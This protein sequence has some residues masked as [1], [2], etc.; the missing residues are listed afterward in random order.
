MVERNM[1]SANLGSGSKKRR[2]YKGLAGALRR[3]KI[4]IASAASAAMLLGQ[5]AK[6]TTDIWSNGA[7]DGLWDTGANWGNGASPITTDDVTF[8]VG[9]YNNILL[10]SGEVANSLTFNDSSYYLTGG[11]LTLGTGNITVNTPFIDTIS[12]TLNGSS[13]LSLAGGGTLNL[14]NTSNGFTGTVTITGSTLNIAG[15][16]SLGTSSNGITFSGTSN[17]NLVNGGT[18]LGA[19]RTITL[20]AAATTDTITSSTN[21]IQTLAGQITGAANLTVTNTGPTLLANSTNNFTGALW[22]QNGTAVVNSLADAPGNGNIRLGNGGSTGVFQWGT[23][24]TGPLTLNNRQIELVGTTGG[25]TIDSSAAVQANTVTINSNLLISTNGAKTLTLQGNNGGTLSS[26]AGTLTGSANTFAGTITDSASGA[27]ALTK[28]GMGLWALTGTGNTY[29]GLTTISTGTLRIGASVASSLTPGNLSLGAA[30]SGATLELR[31][32]VG[33]TDFQNI[34][35]SGSN[36]INSAI[37]YADRAIGNTTA[38]NQTMT[39]GSFYTPF[40]N[41]EQTSL[42][43]DHGYSISIG[44]VKVTPGAATTW[45]FNNF[46]GSPAYVNGAY[47]NG[48]LTL[49][50]LTTDATAGTATQTLAGW[51]DYNLGSVSAAAAN[52]T[53]NLTYSSTGVL[54]FT[55]NNSGWVSTTPGVLSLNNGITRLTGAAPIGTATITFNG[56]TVEFRNDTATNASGINISGLTGNGTI[57][58][59]HTLAGSGSS[60]LLT[61]GTFAATVSKILYVFGD[62]GN[63]LTFSGA[64]T[65][66]GGQ[67][68]VIQNYLNA[69]GFVTAG[70]TPGVLTFGALKA[71]NTAGTATINLAGVGDYVI[72]G[73]ISDPA[74]AI[75]AI[76]KSGTGV[77][78]ITSANN[79]GWAAKAAAVLSLTGGTTRFTT[80]S[81]IGSAGISFGGGMLELR[82]DSPTN[83][84]TNISALTATST[85]EVANSLTGSGN[86]NVMSLGNFAANGTATLNVVGD[87]GN[88][89]TFTGTT[90]VTG[91]KTATIANFLN[92]P[93][94]VTSG[95]APGVITLGAITNDATAGTANLTL[96]GFGDYALTGNITNA[97][98]ATVAL[99]ITK[100]GQGVLTFGGSNTG[101]TGNVGDV[102]TLTSGTTRLTGASP[103]GGAAITL[104]GGLL[105]L[106]NDANTNVATNIAGVTATSTLLLDHSIGNTTDA[107]FV[108]TIGTLNS[109][110]GGTLY[111][112]GDRGYGLTVSGATT[113]VG[114]RTL[115][116]ANFLSAPGYSG[117]SYTPG[118]ITLTNVNGDGTAGVST[119][120][121]SGFGDFNAFDGTTNII[122]AGVGNTAGTTDSLNITKSNLGVATFSGN[123]VNWTSTAQGILSTTLGT[124]RIDVANTN[125][126]GGA[127]LSLGGGMTEIR[128]NASTSWSSH[129]LT[130]NNAAST[131]VVAP[132]IGSSNT[133]N[134]VAL[135]TFTGAGSTVSVDTNHNYG[136]TF[137]AG[138]ASASSVIAN[139]GNGLISLASLTN[140]ATSTYT[141]SGNGDFAVTGNILAGTGTTALTK[142]GY[143]TLALS[144][145]GDTYTG[146]ITLTAGILKITNPLGAAIG[147]LTFN[148]TGSTIPNNNVIAVDLRNN[149]NGANNAGASVLDISTHPFSRAINIVFNVDNNGAGTNGTVVVGGGLSMQDSGWNILVTGGNGYS[150]KF[151]GSAVTNS[152]GTNT[153]GSSYTVFNYIPSIAGSGDLEFAGGLTYINPVTQTAILTL[154]GT[155]D[156]VVSGAITSSATT[157]AGATTLTKSGLGTLTLSGNNSTSY[158]DPNRILTMTN[159]ITR[160]ST[161]ANLGGANLAGANTTLNLNGATLD[162]RNDLG[163]TFTE[164]VTVGAS[165]S[166]INVDQSIGGSGTGQ[167]M[168]LG[169]LK[170]GAFTAFFTNGNNYSLN[171][172][173]LTQTGTN[174]IVN[175]ISGT[176]NLIIPSIAGAQATTFTGSGFTIVSGPAASSL[177]AVTK[178]GTGTVT[179]QEPTA[180]SNTTGNLV[181]NAGSLVADYSNGITNGILTA[182]DTLTLAGGTF[183]L[184]SSNTAS[185]S[186]SQ[187]LGNVAVNAGG[188][189][190]TITPQNG[191]TTILNA[192][193]LATTALGSTLLVNS[194]SVTGVV[195]FNSNLSTIGGRVVL[196]DGANYNWATNSGVNS[197]TTAFTGY[198]S[199]PSSGTFSTTNYLQTDSINVTSGGTLNTLKIT[200]TQAGQ[201]LSLSGATTTVTFA[202]GGLLFTGAN[203]YTISSVDPAQGL[204]SGI[205]TNSDFII[206]QYGTAKLTINAPILHGAGTDSLTIAGTGTVILG[207][208]LGPNMNTY[209]GTTFINA[210]TLQLANA[211]QL[212]TN[213]TTSA[214]TMNG[215]TLDLNGGISNAFSI[216][217]A[218]S[219]GYASTITNSNASAVTLT[220]GGGTPSTTS[221]VSIL[222][223]L[224]NAGGGALSI[225]KTGTG[226]M[227][228]GDV[229]G[230][231]TLSFTGDLSI[232]GSS[233]VTVAVPLT[234]IASTKV[235]LGTPTSTDNP[236][237][238][239][240]GNTN[241]IL[242]S[243]Q[244]DLSNVSNGTINGSGVNGINGTP[245]VLV[246]NSNLLLDG[247]GNKTLTLGGTAG[248]LSPGGAAVSGITGSGSV[249][250]I[251]T[252][253]GT[254]GVNNPNSITLG[255]IV[256]GS[257]GW[258]LTGANTFSGGL[259]MNGTGVLRGTVGNGATSGSFGGSG[260]T[261]TWSAAGQLDLRSETSQNFGNPIAWGNAALKIN[262]DRAPGG[263]GYGQVMTLGAVTETVS[264]Q[265]LTATNTLGVGQNNNGTNPVGGYG[266][267][268]AGLLLNAGTA[269]TISNGIGGASTAEFATPAAGSSVAGAL[270][271]DGI[272]TATNLTHTL[273]IAAQVN[274]TPVTIITGDVVQSSGTTLGINFTSNNLLTLSGQTA[275]TNYSGGVTINN[276]SGGAVRATTFSS[277][278]SG[279]LTLT[280]GNLELRNDSSTIFGWNGS[281]ASAVP[282][283]WSA[284]NSVGMQE[285]EA[286]NGTGGHGNT[287]TLG[288]LTITGVGAGKALTVS[289]ISGSNNNSGDSLTFGG[290]VLGSTTAAT[291]TI[292]NNLLLP[293]M[294]NLG[295]ITNTNAVAA[296]TETLTIAGPGVTTLG[297]I[298]NGTNGSLT[299]ISYTGTGILDLTGASSSAF[300]GGIGTVTNAGGTVRVNNAVDLGGASNVFTWGSASTLEIRSDTNV[301][302]PQTFAVGSTNSNLT[303]GQLP[304]G[305]GSTGG[306]N[307]TVTLALVGPSAQ[308]KVLFITGLGAVNA[309][310]TANANDGYSVTLTTVDI[311][312]VTAAQRLQ[313]G[314]IMTITNNL[315]LPGIVTIGGVA[316]SNTAVG[317]NT[318]VLTI[319]GPGFTSLGNV[320]N[321]A[322]TNL[323]GITYSGAGVLDLSATTSGNS[324]TGG[325]TVTS[326]IVRAS[327]TATST[328]PFG[329]TANT[330]IM[331]GGTLELRSDTS[332]VY[333]NPVS[334]PGGGTITLGQLAGGTATNSDTNIYGNTIKLGTLTIGATGKNLTIAGVDATTA[335]NGYNLELAGVNVN[336]TTTSTITNNLPQPSTVILDGLTTT[337][338]GANILTLAGSGDTRI[339][340]DILNGTGTLQV[341]YSGSGS[342]VLDLSGTTAI[343]ASGTGY[344]GG[345][346]ITGGTVRSTSTN[347]F[348]SSSNTV[349]LGGG[350]L[351]LRTDTSVAYPN[352][353][354][355]LASTTLT[356]GQMPG[357]TSA[358][359]GYKQTITLPSLAATATGAT[360]TIGTVGVSTANATEGYSVAIT[361]VLSNQAATSITNN[362]PMPGTLRISAITSTASTGTN[363]LTIGGSGDTSIL[364]DITNGTGS[365]TTGINVT[366]AAGS[367]VDFSGVT[368]N[369]TY[370][371]GFSLTNNGSA[372]ITNQWGFGAS[373][374]AVTLNG[375]PEIRTDVNVT[376]N[377]PFSITGSAIFTIGQ[378]PGGLGG[379]GDTITL[380]SVTINNT[381]RTVAFNGIGNTAEANGNKVVINTLAIQAAAAT[382][383]LTNG[384]DLPSQLSIGTIAPAEISGGFTFTVN[385][386]GFTNITGDIANAPGGTAITYSGSGILNIIAPTNATNYAG[387]LTINAGGT[388]RINSAFA[389]GASSNPLKFQTG[390]LDIRSDSDLNFANTP[391]TA[392]G[393]GNFTVNADRAVNGTGTGHTMTFANA[394]QITSAATAR[395]YSFTSGDGYN[396]TLNGGV[397]SATASAA[398]EITGSTSGILTLGNGTAANVAYLNT[399]NTGVTTQ[400]FSGTGKTV[401]AGDII[402]GGATGVLTVGIGGTTNGGF[403]DLTAVN[404]EATTPANAYTGGLTFFG[405]ST[406]KIAAA[407]NAGLQTGAGINF[408]ASGATLQVRDVTT[409]NNATIPGF[410][411]S[412]VTLLTGNTDSLDLGSGNGHTGN[413]IAFGALIST[414][415]NT[416]TASTLNVNGINGY[417][418]SFSSATLPSGTGQNTIIVGN[419]PTSILGTVSNP[420]TQI[421]TTHFDPLTLDGVSTGNM[422][423]GAI[424]DGAG[425]LAV[426]FDYTQVTKQGVGTWTLA[427]QSTYTGATTVNAG[428]LRLVNSVTP[429]SLTNTAVSVAAA[430]TFAPGA[431]SSIGVNS[432]TNLGATLNLAAGAKLNLATDG[433][434][435]PFTIL[436]NG[437]FV[438]TT[439]LTLAGNALSFDLGS[440]AGDEIFVGS[441]TGTGKAVATGA[442]SITLNVVTGTTSLLSSYILIQAGTGSTL[443]GGG[444]F[445][446]TNPT[447]IVGSNVYVGSLSTSTNLA[448]ILTFAASTGLFWAS[449][450]LGTASSASWNDTSGLGGTTNFSN[451]AGATSISTATPTSTTNVFFAANSGVTTPINTTLDN[452]FEINSL[453]FTGTATSNTAGSSIAPGS[454]SANSLQI[455]AGTANGNPLGNGINVVGGS[456]ANTISANVVLGGPQT[457]T[458]NNLPTNPLTVSGVVSGVV[459]NTLNKAGTGTLTL[460]G[461]NTFA[462][463]LTLSAGLLNINAQGTASPSASSAIG[464]GT[465]TLTNG[466]F[467]VPA[468]AIDLT[469]TTNNAQVWTDGGSVAFTG[470]NS[471]NMGTGAVAL[472]TGVTGAFIL[473]NNSA[474]AGTSLTVGGAI[475]GGTGGVKT[476]TIGGAGSTA[477]TGNITKGATATGVIIT[478]TSSGT[479][480][481]SGTSAIT[482]LNVN[483]GAGSIVNLGTGSISLTNSGLSFIQSTTGG[484]ING[485]GTA[486]IVLNSTGGGTNFGDNGTANGTT[487]TINAK[488][489]GPNGYEDWGGS[490]TNTGV[491]VLAGIN[492]FTGDIN[493]DGGILSVALIGSTGSTTS[494]LGAGT[495]IS[496]NNGTATSNILRYTGSGETSNRVINLY[497]T[498]GGGGIDQEGTGP[499]KFTANL[500]TPGAGAKTFF[501]LGSPANPAVATGE[502]AGIIKDNG[503]A[504]NATSINKSGTSIWTL[505]GANTYAGSTSIVGGTLQATNSGSLGS[506]LAGRI[507]NQAI[508][509]A[510]VSGTT[511]AATLDLQNGISI[512]RPITLGGSTNGA[513]LINSVAGTTSTVQGDVVA[514]LAFTTN[515]TNLSA[516]TTVSLTGGSGSGAA[517]TAQLGLTAASFTINS[518]TDVYS[519]AP[520]V[521]ISGGGGSGATATAILSGGTSGTVTGVTITA[522]GTGFTAAPNIAFTGGTITS[523]TTA[524]TGSGADGHFTLASITE[525]A[526]GS[527]YTSAPTV[528]LSTGTGFV[529]TS[530][531]PTVTL[532]GTNN[533]IGGTGN[534]NIAAVI[535]GSGG[536]FSKTG[537]GSLTLSA[538]N[539]YTGATAVNQGTLVVNGSINANSAVTVS[540]AAVLAGGTPT[541]PGVI[542]GS[543]TLTSGTTTANSANITAGTG[544]TANDSVGKLSLA[545]AT[546]TF[547][548]N[549]AQI[550]TYDWKYSSATGA[551]T[552]P[553]INAGTNWDVLAITGLSVTGT[554]DVLPVKISG[555]TNFSPGT[556]YQF[557]IVTGVG[558]N[559]ATLNALAAKFQLDPSI[560]TFAAS[561]GGTNNFS[562]FS[563]GDDLSNG[564]E[565]FISYNAAPEPT[566][567]M[568]LGLGVGGLAMRRRRRR[569]AK[570]DA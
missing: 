555:A 104:N 118:I 491:T 395:I 308:P 490:A 227:T 205:A 509:T 276:G 443:Q 479:L 317:T 293:G 66:T 536:G 159:G 148:N 10:G 410:T 274:S 110:T 554:V 285:G 59:D 120:V 421:A 370:T 510:S 369:T 268:I 415:S 139:I 254:I 19:N 21:G 449:G 327:N 215:G 228:L 481:L 448:E 354:A 234:D 134:T 108:T 46:I 329:A 566:S 459:A 406:A 390:T 477:L 336:V 529:G 82:S 303:V 200:T 195:K 365:A 7:K 313:A 156:Y 431:N 544:A 113:V 315:L 37:I 484:T 175:N 93:G 528:T 96:G 290:V 20:G 284:A 386:L 70:Y 472:G 298:A 173:T 551:D 452:T 256:A 446:L 9:N 125:A 368:S 26:S 191:N 56:G 155:G 97:N 163:Q 376:Y 95:Y 387:G 560:A 207:G 543:V 129:N 196:F 499:L 526:I 450:N 170:V 112:V 273:T 278:G 39:L 152:L 102:L 277:L 523:G 394:F 8:T 73:A 455:D 260:N 252:F 436:G 350:T 28:A 88:A 373:T 135:G 266:L 475:T 382:F 75:L 468:A 281:G 485:T 103:I 246:I 224:G 476:L 265:T 302:Y 283:S 462:G 84:A 548:T 429:P 71:D 380:N 239:Y 214:L 54:T 138:T 400:K 162:L 501:L 270:V 318:D 117:A 253:A 454:N 524:P 144:G 530:V 250:T 47:T 403:V 245:G 473:T 553:F 52:T 259:T 172:G 297:N 469:G 349:T 69:P 399:E 221:A 121:L 5:Y 356:V 85:L 348:G 209:T 366:T 388:V 15:D 408:S 123:N 269:T 482:T 378:V 351:E 508:S 50:S 546:N 444:A 43:A 177:G 86:N 458:V 133:G 405:G 442:N 40:N 180:G 539:T 217:G 363:V 433:A 29:T 389:L 360:L 231:S 520:T 114:T 531:L 251:N 320:V 343:T 78:S 404:I 502:I 238:N 41:T 192:G 542:N 202:S 38:S 222:G 44:A 79:T 204:K 291:N 295:A 145:T 165:N 150:L 517:A 11:S 504:G 414:L 151:A 516:G 412:S 346:K 262:V 495:N 323:T 149:G 569:T 106:R 171:T 304:R 355:L 219:A 506:V 441:A 359:G 494:N 16:G 549:G 17:L 287:F 438:G 379:Y 333:T 247:T 233:T 483:G 486:G 465:F 423:S 392:D 62:R 282:I 439:Q 115:T 532:T 432:P 319:N 197:T 341:I 14:L 294:L 398:N 451:D 258:A 430:G 507:L 128:S 417:A 340:G 32:N 220:V 467:D 332:V 567:M 153:G 18:F 330:I 393:T 309:T 61:L 334:M 257:G 201:S 187:T 249:A 100:T 45:Q 518:G 255:L 161:A 401:I 212:G 353:F 176:G 194:D 65:V 206:S 515:P 561:V 456:G 182:T 559:L 324:Y 116:L 521:T 76:T 300:T 563:I 306:F 435:G 367:V 264:G 25:G 87:R 58:V 68:P 286:I 434:A 226:A 416:G 267:R 310:T 352:P 77:L 34:T 185:T 391:I 357:G 64:T 271:I 122:S 396:I 4:A 33:F 240:T 22:I 420:M 289:G 364:G 36:N 263:D 457:W 83:F 23:A 140:S 208:P 402:Q 299:A 489:T 337:A 511:A 67:S 1:P 248:A 288:A 193:T 12:S 51:G 321:G 6:A 181:V 463:G 427:G 464:T 377:N 514:G 81:P 480:T 411:N 541:T 31:S 2:Q 107:N 179:F 497:G 203:D 461:N 24:A 447:L 213:A 311:G 48:S 99:A 331:S 184:K 132:E 381:N 470:T 503:G 301:S 564:G 280:A 199:L 111:V 127:N 316:N 35:A 160:A 216:T 147:G 385:G 136:L 232:T 292:T 565:I 471:F 328:A 53:L 422:I 533:N 358:T 279:T 562:N 190:I 296:T 547:G 498:T 397:T 168:T 89:L 345:F 445:T 74:A 13:G 63:G 478:D 362:L 186:T 261:I 57:D 418:A 3:T 305:T 137:T 537:T 428:T 92:A 568:L 540:G 419:I 496:I 49:A 413:T 55:G 174:T 90:T 347:S 166:T 339:A 424:Q 241:L 91:A 119:L 522:A 342:G 188:G 407:V 42:L 534:L 519:A 141:F 130:L 500:A 157:A 374:N 513:S 143:G 131:L 384:M 189:T 94:F 230:M 375:G 236:T 244:F 335:S 425:S 105:E 570:A 164:T 325:L 218:V 183:Q 558:N 487:L 142:T 453:T 275:N 538:I 512:L 235:N 505:S 550:T 27:T 223:T 525:T 146:A 440:A 557:D 493:I 552:S 326:G 492:T 426:N 167:T 460:S 545:N 488:I 169:G 383:G 527:S 243:R 98:S 198:T 535:A 307:N 361:N 211:S 109:G 242:N 409:S 60:D 372:R 466:T 154:S 124:T 338:V 101:W 126:I 322:G 437:T 158:N 474:L 210:G 312:G 72:S 229:N 371:G 556:N 314:S 30:N 344:T 272:T 80:T 225:V 178:S 237:F